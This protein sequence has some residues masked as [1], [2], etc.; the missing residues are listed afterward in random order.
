[1]VRGKMKLYKRM[2]TES[3]NFVSHETLKDMRYFGLSKNSIHGGYVTLYHGGKKLPV[4]LR[5]GEILF[6][7]PNIEEAQDYANMVKG[8][9]FTLK[10]NPEDVNWNQGSREVEFSKGGVIKNNI[11]IPN[12]EKETDY[13]L[14]LNK[15]KNIEEYHGYVVGD[16]LS[17]NGFYFIIKEI[18]ID[19]INLIHF[20]ILKKNK[21]QKDFTFQVFLKLGLPEYKNK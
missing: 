12:K 5:K 16:I 13:K 15:V 3:Y 8:K 11:I 14:V 6:M 4:R 2:F 20:V 21:K 17:F 18:Y 7:T 19:D 1:M 9:V 10:V